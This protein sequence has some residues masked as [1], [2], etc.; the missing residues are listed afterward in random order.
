MS[1]A[2]NEQDSEQG[3]LLGKAGIPPFWSQHLPNSSVPPPRLSVALA[4]SPDKECSCCHQLGTMTL[5]FSQ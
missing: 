4:A 2:P 3:D 5:V 1:S